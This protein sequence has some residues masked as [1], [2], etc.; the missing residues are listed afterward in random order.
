M[1]EEL[2]CKISEKTI[3]LVQQYLAQLAKHIRQVKQQGQAIEGQSRAG[4]QAGQTIKKHAQAME[5]HLVAA[6]ELANKLQQTKSTQVYTQM[7]SEH[8]LAVQKHILATRE[9]LKYSKSKET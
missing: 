6:K 5:K 3:E 8:I 7:Q 9:F 4:T 1:S 2:G